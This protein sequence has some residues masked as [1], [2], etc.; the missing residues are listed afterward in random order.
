[1]MYKQAAF[2]DADRFSV[3]PMVD[4]TNSTFRRIARLLSKR[5]MLY[6]EMIVDKAVLRGRSSLLDFCPEELPCVL[7][8][9][10]SEPATLAEA[11]KI[12]LDRGYSALNLNAGCPSDK[13]QSGDF[14]AVLMKT[15]DLIGD[16]VKALQDATGTFVS[17]KTRIGVD[18][19]DSYEYTM[20]IVKAVYDAG[21]RHI[22]M[23]A[24]KAWLN[25]L[26]PKE[27]RSVPPLNYDRVYAVKEQFPDLYVT[28]NGGITSIEACREQLAKVD[29][30]MLGRAVSDN[31]YLLAMVDHELYG[32]PDPILTRE[33]ILN[34]ITDFSEEYLKE[35]GKI[36]HVANHVLNLF[37]SCPGARRFRQYLSLHMSEEGMG[38]ELFREAYRQMH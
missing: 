11:G 28:I 36:K 33:E 16:C 37:N 18:E 10:G 8:L 20:K 5:A 26:S 34:R 13:V 1:M 2:Q 14:G 29:G 4:I 38:P 24:R 19:C 31:P 25:G 17:V 15:P 22:I 7:Q 32:E 27:N 30:V 9:G 35:G 3:A 23:H 12:A 21:C 6:T